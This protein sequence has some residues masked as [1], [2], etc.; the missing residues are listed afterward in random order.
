MLRRCV[1]PLLL[2]IFIPATLQSRSQQNSDLRILIEGEPSASRAMTEAMRRSIPSYNFKFQFVSK[3]VDQHDMRFIVTVGKGSAWCVDMTNN[4]TNNSPVWYFYG[5][6]VALAP[7]GRMLFTVS[8]SGSTAKQAMDAVAT[9]VA[10]NLYNY[11]RPSKENETPSYGGGGNRESAESGKISIQG[12]PAEPGIYYKDKTVWT[13][14]RE[15]FASDVKA[16]GVGAALLTGGVSGIRIAQVY[17]G[18]QGQ[19]QTPERKP[20]FYVR[21]SAV[22]ERDAVIARLVKKKDYRE[23]Q[24]GAIAA[25]KSKPGYKEGDIYKV[26]VARIADDIYEIMPASELEPGEYLL[27]LSRDGFEG[28]YE[29]GVASMKK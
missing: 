25:F 3:P 19:A 10:K 14:L 29:F 1:L 28:V 24:V 22:S 20:T 12:L 13:R 21:G 9:D 7:D 15:G 17:S 11:S 18:A 8:Q 4:S 6:V 16:R 26:V 23:I 2:I 5:G 27:N